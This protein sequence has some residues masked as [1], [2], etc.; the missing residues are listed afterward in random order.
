MTNNVMRILQ[1]TISDK[2]IIFSNGIF[3][4]ITL[5]Q[6]SFSQNAIWSSVTQ[7]LYIRNLH[8]IAKGVLF[9]H[10]QSFG[11]ILH[12]RLFFHLFRPAILK[13]LIYLINLHCVIKTKN[14]CW[15]LT[16]FTYPSWAQ[17]I[18]M[19]EYSPETKKKRYNITFQK[20]L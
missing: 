5:P 11:T 6:N 2:G 4:C 14:K 18:K 9:N 12:F 3:L 13:K 8:S 19:H 17:Q 15:L 7:L 20:Y 10:N 16:A 1:T